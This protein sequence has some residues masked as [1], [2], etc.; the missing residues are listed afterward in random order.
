V[1]TRIVPF[2]RPSPDNRMVLK[3][4]N[5]FMEQNEE[6]EDFFLFVDNI[7]NRFEGPSERPARQETSA[8]SPSVAKTPRECQTLLEELHS[9]SP[10]LDI[11]ERFFA[12]L[13]GRS[14]D[15]ALLVD[16]ENEDC[17]T[18]MV[19]SELAMEL[20]MCYVSGHRSVKED[21]DSAKRTDDGVLRDH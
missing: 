20:L 21:N 7:N 14:D 1:A 11:D 9:H 10:Q 2:S 3:T 18:V 5:R 13:N 8:D 6:N 15:S 4:L 12:L 17:G 19:A 16:D